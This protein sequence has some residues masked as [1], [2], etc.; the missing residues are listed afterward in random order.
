MRMIFYIAGGVI[1]FVIRQA[2]LPIMG[3]LADLFI[4][5]WP[6]F[7]WLWHDDERVWWVLL[8]AAALVDFTVVRV[9]PFYLLASKTALAA[10][11]ALIVPYL[12][13]GTTLTR[14]L[15]LV[16]WL[17]IWRAAYIVWLILGWFAGGAPLDLEQPVVWPAFGW[18]V[19]GLALASMAVA[20]V[21]LVKAFN[22]RRAP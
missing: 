4:V 11:Y 10:C 22:K 19:V 18:L 20:L 7:V 16:L 17:V 12:S 9:L 13:Y 6:A 14:L 2:A 5:I 1:L 15:T 3:S 8:I 21:R